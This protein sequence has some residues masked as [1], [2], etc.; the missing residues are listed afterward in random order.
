MNKIREWLKGKKTYLTATIGVLGALLA[1]A[2]SQI[3]LMALLAS[4]WAAV[5]ACWIHA[6]LTRGSTIPPEGAASAADP[7]DS[8]SSGR[9]S[10]AGR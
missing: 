2:D 8:P 10:S 3:D 1:Y 5:Q 9:A 7:A 6:A 4:I